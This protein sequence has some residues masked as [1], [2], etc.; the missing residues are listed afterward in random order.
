MS[1]FIF[2][3]TSL[4]VAWVRYGVKRMGVCGCRHAARR[5]R[6]LAKRYGD[7]R[8]FRDVDLRLEADGFLLAGAFLAARC[9]FDIRAVIVLSAACL[10]AAE[11]RRCASS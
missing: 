6:Q 8:V 10:G 4:T 2:W 7:R 9:Y 11:Q 3:L 5:A 1:S